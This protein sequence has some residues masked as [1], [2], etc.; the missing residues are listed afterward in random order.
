MLKQKLMM[1]EESYVQ[2]FSVWKALFDDARPLRER[3]GFLRE[4]VFQSIDDPNHISLV[5][6]VTSE[7]EAK[8][9]MESDLLREYLDRGGVVGEI[10]YVFRH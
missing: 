9:W 4:S 3:H 7:C 8:K 10:K 1:F 5:F 2:D 6:E